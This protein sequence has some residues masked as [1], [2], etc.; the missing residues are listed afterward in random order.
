M[1]TYDAG[2]TKQAV[3]FFENNLD[4]LGKVQSI[5]HE[6][7]R[8]ATF[9]KTTIK[10]SEETLVINNA[11]TSGFSGEGPRGLKI[12]LERLGVES[13]DAQFY[14]GELNS[15]KNGFTIKF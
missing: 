8:N 1:I 2:G 11:L 12:V 5:E 10:G 14:T 3:E 13:I 4:F 15:E 7:L 9:Y 6:V